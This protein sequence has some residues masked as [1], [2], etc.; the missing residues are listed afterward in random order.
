MESFRSDVRSFSLHVI[1][2]NDELVVD[3]SGHG[4][5]G[6]G[7]PCWGDTVVD[8]SLYFVKIEGPF[9]QWVESLSDAEREAV[10]DETWEAKRQH[11]QYTLFRLDP[12]GSISTIGSIEAPVTAM[13]HIDAEARELVNFCDGFYRYD[14][15][16]LEPIDDTAEL[17]EDLHKL[18]VEDFSAQDRYTD[19]CGNVMDYSYSIPRLDANTQGARAINAEIGKLTFKDCVNLL[20][21]HEIEGRELR[22]NAE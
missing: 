16:T 13:F 21:R 4:Y 14:L 6:D 2:R 22:C 7:G 3:Y 9:S 19:D 5:Y 8:G 18:V 11:E 1:D 12:D 17:P 20:L 15:F 10:T